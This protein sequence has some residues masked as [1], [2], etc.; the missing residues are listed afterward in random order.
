MRR[1][2]QGF[3]LIELLVVVAVIAVLAALLFPVFGR[4]RDQAYKTQCLSNLHQLGIALLDYVQD[5]DDTLPSYSSPEFKQNV[6]WSWKDSIF[7]YL[8][9][10]NVFLCPSN[11]VGWDPSS[12]YWGVNLSS[13]FYDTLPKGSRYPISYGMNYALY[14]YELLD[15]KTPP[16]GGVSLHDLKDPLTLIALGEVRFKWRQ[17]L[18]DPEGFLMPLIG[19]VP[20]QRQYNGLFHHHQGWINWVFLDGHVRSLKAVQTMEPR[21]AWGPSSLFGPTI[22][23]LRFNNFRYLEDHLLSEYR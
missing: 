5:Y 12:S 14:R 17:D 11:P 6:H 16:A 18:M 2:H 1:T 15:G 3:T 23:A 10:K 9:N 19:G 22:T 7:P 4:A 20:R 13:E 8:K 21:A